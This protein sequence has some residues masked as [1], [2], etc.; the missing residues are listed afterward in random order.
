MWTHAI[1][2]VYAD[3]FPPDFDA[4]EAIAEG[5]VSYCNGHACDL[6]GHIPLWRLLWWKVLHWLWVDPLR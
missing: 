1:L 3:D 2:E 6:V 5:R 4:A